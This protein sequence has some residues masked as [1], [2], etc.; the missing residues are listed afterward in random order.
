MGLQQSVDRETLGGVLS[1]TLPN[2]GMAAGSAATNVGALGGDLTG[3]LPNPTFAMGKGAGGSPN[4]PPTTLVQR[5]SAGYIFNS[6]FNTTADR[7]AN[8]PLY[9]AYQNGDNYLRWTS[10]IAA[11]FIPDASLGAIKLQANTINYDRLADGAVH[12]LAS[13]Q[14][15]ASGG[16]TS[17]T[18]LVAMPAPFNSLS[19]SV[20]VAARRVL[21]LGMFFFTGISANAVLGITY[22]WDGG[23]QTYIFNQNIYNAGYFYVPFVFFTGSL[24]VASHALNFYWSINSGS[25]AFRTDVWSWTLAMDIRA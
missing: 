7:T 10:Q 4:T 21:V 25:V 18:T 19:L 12:G 2:P 13:I 22:A 5:D 3:T 14:A 6:Y 8:A 17:S 15:T 9:L 16:S 23:G 1:G 24:S 11:S 20:A